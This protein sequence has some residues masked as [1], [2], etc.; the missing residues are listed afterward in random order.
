MAPR[1]KAKTDG[2]RSHPPMPEVLEED[3]VVSDEDM[4]FVRQ[5]DVRFLDRLEQM[6]QRGE[7]DSQ[8]KKKTMA[9]KDLEETCL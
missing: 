2:K 9:K 1:S 5:H 4:E 8:G 7:E 6:V 3:L